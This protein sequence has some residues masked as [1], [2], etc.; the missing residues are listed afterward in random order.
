MKVGSK[1]KEVQEVRGINCIAKIIKNSKDDPFREAPFS[2][3]FGYGLDD[4]RSNLQ[5]YK[6]MTGETVY[7]CT[8]GKTYQSIEYAV[9]YVEQNNLETDLK[10]NVIDLWEEIREKFKEKRQRKR[11][12]R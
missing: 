4:I 12:T 11:K 3:V 8:D 2:I 7:N 5:W 6:D 9:H 1:N 10:E